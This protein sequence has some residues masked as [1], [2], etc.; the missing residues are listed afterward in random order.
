[1]LVMSARISLF[2]ILLTSTAL[3][4]ALDARPIKYLSSC[5]IDLSGSSEDD[6][7]ML[8]ETKQGREL[9]VL[10]RE[11][12][13]FRPVVVQK[14]SNL[15]QITCLHAPQVVGYQNG[16]KKSF[17]TSGGYIRLYQPEGSAK[18]LFFFE[19]KLYETWVSK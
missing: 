2:I 11:A 6:L 17:K 16:K 7:A 14:V 12:K 15:H 18:A 9:I 8:V 13:S 5:E 4:F 10:I 1:M 19:D 3:S